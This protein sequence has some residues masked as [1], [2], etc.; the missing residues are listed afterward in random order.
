MT[1]KTYARGLWD[2]RLILSYTLLLSLTFLI[3]S[4]FCLILIKS[5]GKNWFGKLWFPPTFTLD[6]YK[7][8]IDVALLPEVMKN[9]LLVAILAVGMSTIIGI[10]TGWAFGRRR[11]PGKEVLMA[12]ILLP[13]M[14]PSITY[15]LGI[16]RIFYSLNLVNTYFGIALSHVALCAPYAILVL[17]ATFEGLDDRMLEAAAV[18][19]ANPLRTFFHITLPTIMPGI[20]SSMIFTF[21][22]SYN[23]FT[24]TL[25]TYGPDTITLPIRTYLAVGDGYWEVTS[26]MSVIMVLPSL[27]ILYL[28]QRQI[29]PEQLVGGFKGL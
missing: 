29:K 14:I 11:L 26:A 21:T 9:T 5:F 13:R 20:L 18:C 23:E 2:G 8:A 10:F 25:M 6:W 19:G 4:P 27:F 17:S 28:I 12:L 15:A 24:L 1:G 22:T 16:A 3:L 7:W